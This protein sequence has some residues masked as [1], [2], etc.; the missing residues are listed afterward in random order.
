[1]SPISTAVVLIEG[2]LE[3]PSDGEY[4][5]NS[6]HSGDKGSCAKARGGVRALAGSLNL[7]AVSHDE[8]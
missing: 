3:I 6:V 7:F 5:V 4:F 8:R 1:M 2:E